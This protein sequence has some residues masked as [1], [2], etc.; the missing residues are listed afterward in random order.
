[1]PRKTF[2]Q[3]ME[4]ES[5]IIMP[6]CAD[7]LTSRMAKQIG[8]R[9]FAIGGFAMSGVRYGLMDVGLTSL[10]EAV[11]G[12]RDILKGS[13]LPVFVDGG[14]GYGDVKNVTRSIREFEELGAGCITIEDQVSPKRCYGV[15]KKSVI[16]TDDMLRKLD[17]ALH[18]R[19]SD[20]TWI[21]GRTDARGAE[22]LE[23]AVRRA[24]K[25]VELGVDGLFVDGLETAEEMELLSQRCGVPKLAS[26]GGAGPAPITDI[27][28]LERLGYSLIGYPA[29]ILLRVVTAIRDGLEAIKNNQL[30]L[31]E[32]SV[33]FSEFAD[34][35]GLEQWQG[36]EKRYYGGTGLIPNSPYHSETE[37]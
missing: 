20:D 12:V 30:E 32:N 16:D 31:P 3:L 36:I 2:K 15:T 14:D 21:I 9:A 22:G 8:F 35:L 25:F 23:E 19:R 26:L 5:P 6:V 13:D 34:C 7:A 33:T 4:D 24:E 11:D 18:A 1:M 17:A 29:S 10:G 27:V 37:R 28:E